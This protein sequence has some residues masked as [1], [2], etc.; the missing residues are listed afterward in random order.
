MNC[1][2]GFPM[3]REVLEHSINQRP[4]L[5]MMGRLVWFNFNGVISEMTRTTI[6]LI[7]RQ[8]LKLQQ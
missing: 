4:H 2:P 1:R 5:G 6:D 8:A 3:S 7:H